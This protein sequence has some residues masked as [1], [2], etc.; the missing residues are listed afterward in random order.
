MRSSSEATTLATPRNPA[1]HA[2]SIK[3]Q[4]PL[5]PCP[6]ARLIAS[7]VPR[8]NRLYHLQ[9]LGDHVRSLLGWARGALTFSRS[10]R[11]REA[12]WQPSNE[13][14]C[15][16]ECDQGFGGLST[17]QNTKFGALRLAKHV[18][19]FAGNMSGERCCNSTLGVIGLQPFPSLRPE[20]QPEHDDERLPRWWGNSSSVRSAN[21]ARNVL[22]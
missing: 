16:D 12:S 2:P 19:R 18:A 1:A 3:I 17:R 8:E 5:S 13:G 6:G 15:G 20:L 7:R 9:A 21:P 4:F 11:V 14:G 22:V 10:E